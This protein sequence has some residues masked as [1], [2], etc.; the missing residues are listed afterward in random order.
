MKWHLSD[1]DKRNIQQNDETEFQKFYENLNFHVKK[2][3]VKST[4]KDPDFEICK[5]DQKI[6]V[7]LKSRFGDDTPD[8][9]NTLFTEAISKLCHPY[10]YE[11]R[12]N[13]RIMPTSKE[14][15]N[16]VKL[17][18]AELNTL[19]ED[20]KLP[21]SLRLAEYST[22]QL[23]DKLIKQ[24]PL[25][26]S[27]YIKRRDQHYRMHGDEEIA[28]TLTSKNK[29]GNMFCDMIFGSSRD[30]LHISE[31]AYFDRSLKVAKG[32]LEQ[33]LYTNVVGVF[34]INHSH[35]SWD[36]YDILRL[37]GDLMVSFSRVPTNNQAQL[38]LGKN[39]VVGLDKKSWLSF[40]GYYQPGIDK[41][42]FIY[43][44][45]FAKVKL[46]SDYFNLPSIDVKT[47]KI[48]ED[49]TGLIII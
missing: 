45:A 24:N 11:F 10:N 35:F 4:D 19:P 9:I 39:R 1:N 3:D 12:H 23:F 7:E 34:F 15:S 46:D 41:K 28:I 17:I 6:I 14:I 16:K 32:Q 37:Y 38:V 25:G 49:N 18:Q 30:D 42:R 31:K 13:L 20:L 22:Q 8:K 47:I 2:L 43:I 48:T 36:E 5:K 29:I 44:N 40:I 33:Y 26:E 21:Y 27:S